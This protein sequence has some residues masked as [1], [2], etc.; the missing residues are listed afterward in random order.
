MIFAADI[1]NTEIALALF[2]NGGLVRAWRLKTVRNRTADEYGAVLSALIQAAGHRP[3]R[4]EDICAAS[5]AP[6]VTQTFS[7]ACAQYLRRE[8]LIVSAESDIGIRLDVDNPSEVGADR[9]VNALAAAELYPLP[10]VVVD[11]GTATNLDVIGEGGVFL[12][13]AF[14][15]GIQV[16][17]EALFQRASMLNPIGNIEKPMRA[18]GKNTAECLQSGLYHGF[19][20]QMERMIERIAEELE[21]QPTVVATGG[22]SERIARNS[23][24]VDA[25][26]PH[27]TLKGL[28]F[29]RNRLRA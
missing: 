18:I 7:E 14:M 17:I 16:S 24:L 22:L 5:V 23:A 12:G 9:A 28:L 4:V 6:A 3:E 8:P 21:A 19:L 1:G 2:K 20:G 10:A 13:G 29:A 27:L 15:P 11:F 25:V 26:D